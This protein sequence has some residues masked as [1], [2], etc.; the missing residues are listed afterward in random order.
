MKIWFLYILLLALGNAALAQDAQKLDTTRVTGKMISQLEQEQNSFVYKI[1]SSEIKENAVQ[2]TADVLQNSGQVM[3]Q[4]SQQGGGSPILR[5]FEANKILLVVDGIRLNNLIF[6]GG[7]LQN[8]IGIDPLSLHDIRVVMGQGSTIYGS[9]ALGGVIHLETM[10]SPFLDGSKQTFSGNLFSKFSSANMGY[11]LHGDAAYSNGNWAGVT[12]LSYSHY[13]DLRM[14]GRP[15]AYPNPKLR[16]YFV[17]PQNGDSIRKNANQLVQKYSGYEQYDLLQKIKYRHHSRAESEL[18]LQYSTTG[19]VPRY[20]RL[21]TLDQNNTLRYA[22][23]FYGPQCRLLAAYRLRHCLRT[24]GVLDAQVYYQNLKESRYKRLRNRPV[25]NANE[26]NVEVIG[27][28]A[29]AVQTR[30]TGMIRYGIDLHRGSVK[31]IGYSRNIHTDALSYY[32]S[33]YPDGDNYQWNAGMYFLRQ[34]ALDADAFLNIGLRAGYTLL[35]SSI[36]AGSPNPYMLSDFRQR[37]PVYSF[38]LNWKKNYG[39]WNVRLNLGSGYRVPNLD[40][41]AKIFDSSPGI[42][43]VPNTDLKPEKTLNLNTNFGYN[44][45]GISWEFS[46][47]ASYLIDAIATRPF[48]LDG[49]DSVLFD[50]TLSAV[51]ANQNFDR[52]ILYGFNTML[53]AEI[54]QHWSLHANVSYT[55]GTVYSEGMSN[56]PLDHIPPTTGKIGIGHQSTEWLEMELYCLFNGWKK[57]NT[58]SSSGEDNLQY[59]PEINGE[60]IGMPRWQIFNFSSSWNVHPRVKMNLGV[61]NIFDLRYQ[62]FA[63]G[64][65]ASGRNFFL[66]INFAF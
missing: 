31:S 2:T 27:L 23:W 52:G 66:G 13:A 44:S 41:L 22:E 15:G 46:P 49:K 47:Y 3:V 9:D 17:D 58:Y 42:F 33:R 34:W 51:V 24:H 12:S 53:K 25:R 48:Q 62:V 16:K 29:N 50:G 14:G 6:R 11:N 40:D 18:N 30:N 59:V 38:D 35:H 7:H 1:K 26:E 19:A 37:N 39:P 10:K 45:K 56:R 20:D 36:S 64:I 55:F 57:L 65:L 60:K 28:T 32:Q 54:T 63:S 5:G 8:I 4:K 21:T 61:E 43:I